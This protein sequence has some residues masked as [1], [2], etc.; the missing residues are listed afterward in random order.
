MK[1]LEEKYGIDVTIN[2]FKHLRV[3]YPE[4]PLKLLIVGK[5]TKENDFKDQVKKLNLVPDVHFTGWIPIE[6]VPQYH[7]YLDI[8]VFPSDSESFGVA[9]VEA[10]GCAKPVIV[11]RVGGLVEVVEENKTGLVVPPRN[12]KALA[13]AMEKLVLDPSLRS[14]LGEAGRNRVMEIYDWDKNLRQMME[15]YEKN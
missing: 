12:E 1:L 15:F 14:K 2:A 4:L 11:S 5:G 7:N 3:K 9:A 10:S 8:S 6:R 13:E